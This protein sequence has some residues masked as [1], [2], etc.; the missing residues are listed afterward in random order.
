VEAGRGSEVGFTARV[1]VAHG[2]PREFHTALR[3]CKILFTPD[4]PNRWGLTP[5]VADISLTHPFVGNAVDREQWDTNQGKGL[6]QRAQMKR[7]KQA[8]AER[9]LIVVPLVSDTLGSMT[10]K[11][12]VTLCLFAAVQETESPIGCAP[13]SSCLTSER[14]KGHRPRCP[15]RKELSV[16]QERGCPFP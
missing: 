6:C 12:A 5:I 1:D 13:E 2:L 7:L 16:P 4:H 15:R 11:S 9:N 8:W 14:G 3:I 10:G